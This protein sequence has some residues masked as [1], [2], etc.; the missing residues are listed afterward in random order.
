MIDQL[1]HAQAIPEPNKPK[2]RWRPIVITS[3]AVV[4]LVAGGIAGFSWWR[5][6]RTFEEINSIPPLPSVVSAES[7]GVESTVVIDTG[8]AQAAIATAEAQRKT[9]GVQLLP[10]PTPNAQQPASDPSTPENGTPAAQVFTITQGSIVL[11]SAELDSSAQS[12]QPT[13]LATPS[14]T[15]AASPQASTAGTPIIAP[16]SPE[17]ASSPVVIAPPTPTPVLSSIERLANGDF[18]AGVDP[19]YLE[20]GATVG[21]GMAHSG[22]Y[23]LLFGPDGGYGNQQFT[24]NTGTNYYAS[25]WVIASEPGHSLQI[26]VAY[27]DADGNRRK[28]LEPERPSFAVT[29]TYQQL[30]F[31]FTPPAEVAFAQLTFYKSDLGGTISIDDVSLRAELSPDLLQAPTTIREDE[32]VTIL[33]MGVDARPGEPIDQGVRPDSL[34]VVRLNPET[35]SCR[36]LAL[37]RDTRVDLPG[38][39]LSKINH[40]LAVGGIP[41]E[42]LVVE[43]YLGL[44]ID[45]YV[46]IDFTGFSELVDDVGGIDILVPEA[47]TAS[48]GTFFQAGQQHM[49]GTQALAYS[50]FRGDADGDF[51]RIKRQQQLIQALMA[52]ASDINPVEAVTQ[53]VP[54]LGDRLRTDLGQSDMLSLAEQYGTSCTDDSVEFLTLD[55]SIA[56]F[57]DP[58]LNMPLSYVVIDEAELRRKVAELIGTS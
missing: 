48:D 4:L 6:H 24:V 3:L 8:P 26:G 42:Q 51:G 23:S 14:A 50:R 37:P 47:F 43:Q 36:V 33:V 40:A 54:S 45:H 31:E 10:T 56:T 28:D 1:D 18:E 27:Y 44:A 12:A 41:Y 55:G 39:G 25:A 11:T 32:S 46:L 57:D 30:A 52:K 58:L 15:P 49:N 16:A 19:W 34:M 35:G 20:A 53:L 13:V 21:L 5:V 29:T 9:G 17:S 22:T 7:L 38:Y 2:R